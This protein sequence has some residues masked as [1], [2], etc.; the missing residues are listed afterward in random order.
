MR[1]SYQSVHATSAVFKLRILSVPSISGFSSTALSGTIYLRTS[2]VYC[3]LYK[4]YT[5][6]Q[7]HIG[8][9]VKAEVTKTVLPK[10]L[11]LLH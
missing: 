3:T 7:S 5:L 9:K 6:E 11:K 8:A 2:R 10:E 1:R 4:R